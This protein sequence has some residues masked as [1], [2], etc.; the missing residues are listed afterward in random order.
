[1]FFV[2]KK[3]EKKRII[4]NEYNNIV[5]LVLKI[6]D[7]VVIYLKNIFFDVDRNIFLLC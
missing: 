1:M 7:I 3:N 5:Y 2:F 4:R 6:N